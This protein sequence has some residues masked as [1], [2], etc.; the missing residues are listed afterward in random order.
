MNA[1]QSKNNPMKR[2]LSL[3]DF[4]LLFAGATMHKLAYAALK[5]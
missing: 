5:A 4:R 3:R 2:V 1:T